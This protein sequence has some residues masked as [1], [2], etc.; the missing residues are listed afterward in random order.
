VIDAQLASLVKFYHLM[1]THNPPIHIHYPL[2][3]R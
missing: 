3:R 2:I 1:H